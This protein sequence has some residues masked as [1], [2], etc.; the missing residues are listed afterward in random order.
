MN[1]PDTSALR[2]LACPYCG[3]RELEEFT[4][5]KTLPPPSSATPYAR[6][7]ER[8]DSLTQSLEHWQHL[9]GCRAWLLVN[10][11]PSSGAVVSVRLLSA[12]ES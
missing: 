7:Y 2:T 9:R 10:R 6:I 8:V 5:R 11:N 4:F 1:P 3:P 12:A